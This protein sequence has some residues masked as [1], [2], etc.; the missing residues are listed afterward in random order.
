MQLTPADL[1]KIT[2]I[3]LEHYDQ[4]A[5]GFWEGTRDHDVSQNLA[6]LLRGDRRRAAVH[7]SRLRLRPGPR[8]RRVPQARAH[9]R[10]ASKARRAS[11]RWRARYSG[12]EVW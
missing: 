7:D 4:S 9:G 11:S 1:A 2:A 12:C 3:T 5:D 6:A 8:P 10:S